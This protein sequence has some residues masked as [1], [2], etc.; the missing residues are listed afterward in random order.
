MF[1]S[2][3]EN[4]VSLSFNS[5]SFK[6]NE[7]IKTLTVFSVICMPLS[8]I[9]SYFGMNFEKYEYSEVILYLLTDLSQISL[10]GKRRQL[11][12]HLMKSIGIFHLTQI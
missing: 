5:S 6:L 11:V 8:L 12:S 2:L 9:T 4:L 3:S 7:T 1:S 10:I